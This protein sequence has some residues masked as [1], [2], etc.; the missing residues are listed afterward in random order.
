MPSSNALVIDA[1]SD[2]NR[3]ELARMV[4]LYEIPDF[5][6]QANLDFTM[7]PDSVA[8]NTYAD[9]VRQKFACHTAAATWVSGMYFHEKK[10]EYHPKDRQRI[11]S[12]LESYVDYWRIRP[13]YDTLV[14]KANEL[15]SQEL[16]DSS[17]AYVWVD[18]RGGK[19]R[20]LPLNSSMNIKAAAEWLHKYQ[21]RL[22]FSDRNV[23]AKKILE[24][25][26]NTGTSLGE[27]LGEY[28]EKQAGH[29]IPDPSEVISMIKQ[30]AALATKATHKEEILKLASAVESQARI[31]LQPTE[32]VKL[33]ETIDIIDSALHLKGKYT[34]SIKR[35]EDVIFKVTFTKAAS[36]KEELC[37]LQTGNVYSKDQLSKLAKEDVESLF[38]TDFANEVCTGFDVD[39]VKM[40][41]VAHTLPTPD[42]ELLEH[43]LTETGQNPAFGKVAS[44]M[45]PSSE[46]MEAL[47]KLYS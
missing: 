18:D 6:K 13:A 1:A 24:K 3:E 21:D 31:A 44:R 35:P 8:I 4:K 7:N 2:T 9:P 12:R 17:Y 33:A 47:A 36:D 29:G 41:E 45:E 10:A 11:E 25:S 42:A 19:E 38:G 40:A 39:P 5:V 20:Y 26:A 30:R 34:D 43:L 22:P 14:K 27:N 32:L 46:D 37:T 15:T 28:T 16:P 23:I